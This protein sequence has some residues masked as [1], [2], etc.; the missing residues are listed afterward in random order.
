M[1]SNYIISLTIKTIWVLLIIFGLLTYIFPEKI[2]GIPGQIIDKTDELMGLAA[3]D[4]IKGELTSAAGKF[5]LVLNT[6][7]SA[8][9]AAIE[10][11]RIFTNRGNKQKAFKV[12]EKSIEQN[13]EKAFMCHYFLADLFINEGQAVRAVQHLKE[14]Y[15]TEP[16]SWSVFEKLAD[17]Y[18]RADDQKQLQTALYMYIDAKTNY[19]GIILSSLKRDQ[20]YSK[21]KEKEKINKLITHPENI[22]PERFD[23]KIFETSVGHDK[24]IAIAYLHLYYSHT[25]TGEYEIARQNLKSA[26]KFWPEMQEALTR[27]K[28]IRP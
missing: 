1:Q 27:Y 18:T 6:D 26:I 17:I 12:I 10:L 11:A 28:E 19:Q 9:E 13:P 2:A 25:K 4:L 8:T 5:E 20:I 7:P 21:G 22:I 14:A 24:S 15:K 3:N 23:R 16:F